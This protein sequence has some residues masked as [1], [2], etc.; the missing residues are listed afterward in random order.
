MRSYEDSAKSKK[1]VA[2]MI[3]NKN[4]KEA[5]QISAS[6]QSSPKVS[7]DRQAATVGLGSENGKIDE[8]Q[9]LANLN[10][11][12]LKKGGG[13]KKGIYYSNCPCC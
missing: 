11:L 2:S 13:A 10:A 8:E 5:K 12:K 4:G 3:E 9:R 7:N 1:T 6:L